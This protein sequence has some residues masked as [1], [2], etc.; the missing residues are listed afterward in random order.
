MAA[1][2]GHLQS[3]PAKDNGE[4]WAYDVAANKWTEMKPPSGPTGRGAAELAYDAESDRVILFGGWNK[5]AGGLDDTWAYDYNTNTW[6]EM[7]KGPAKHLGARLAYDAESDRIIL[8]GGYDMTSGVL[9]QR[10]LGLRLQLGYL[11]G[12]ETEYQP[13]R[14]ELSGH[15]L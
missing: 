11:D 12:D 9:L 10:H 2:Q 6:T 13:S 7:A 5:V 3:D 4:T 14:P 15:G 1:R 8:F